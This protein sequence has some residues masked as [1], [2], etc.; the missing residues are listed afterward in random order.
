LHFRP[1]KDPSPKSYLQKQPLRLLTEI[2][3][4]MMVIVALGA[5]THSLPAAEAATFNTTTSVSCPIS[6]APVLDHER[7]CTAK[8]SSTGIGTFIDAQPPATTKFDFLNQSG[9]GFFP[10]GVAG[11][12]PQSVNA[13][14]AACT[15]R[16]VSTTLAAHGIQ[17]FF[18]AENV[19]GTEY[20]ESNAVASFTEANISTT[21][22]VSCAPDTVTVGE[23][24]A[25]TATVGQHSGILAAPG[26]VVR[27][28]SSERTEFPNG[29]TCTLKAAAG[30]QLS[31]CTVVLSPLEVGSGTPLI[32]VTYPGVAPDFTGSEKQANDLIRVQKHGTSTKLACAQPAQIGVATTC[33]ATVSDAVV[34]TKTPPSGAVAFETNGAGAFS[35]PSCAVLQKGTG[36][37]SCSVT[38]TPVSGA[39]HT[40]VAS[41]KGDSAHQ[42]SQGNTNL[43][44]GGGGGKPGA[45]PNTKLGTKPKAKTSSPSAKFTFVSDQ[46]GSTFRCKLDKGPFKACHS[47]FKVKVKPGKHTLQVRA[48][49]S[50][51]VSDP[52]PAVFH[53]SVSGRK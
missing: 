26:G 16:F 28:E 47:P 38:Y 5:A 43:V 44:L 14:E 51:G 41:Y 37:F 1:R 42:P 30:A 11:C 22:G 35:A 45:A 20:K 32:K 9:L 48:V 40:L 10:G 29:F 21:T 15:A 18:S 23:N 25:C 36:I 8:V 2:A 7:A 52:T 53:W 19:S 49:N 6:G 39:E 3:A 34:G 13:N 24:S 4:A 46:P 50:N 27:F 33:T 31:T 17:A 12:T